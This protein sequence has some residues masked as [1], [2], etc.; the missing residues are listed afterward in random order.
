M[1]GCE[2]IPYT[3]IPPLNPAVLC[4]TCGDPLTLE[5]ERDEGICV[6]CLCDQ[7]HLNPTSNERMMA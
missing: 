7:A 4:S 2:P 1:E 5:M 3:T 6:D